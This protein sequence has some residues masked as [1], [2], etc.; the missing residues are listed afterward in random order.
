[1]KDYPVIKFTILFILGILSAEVIHLNLIF[2]IIIFLATSI[3]ILLPK[4]IKTNTYYSLL[5]LLSAGVL[6]FSI[7]NLLSKENKQSFNPYLSKIDKVKNTIA[8][9]EI[10]KIDL[11][12][13]NQLN[14]YLS[15][16]SMKSDKFFIKDKFLLLC[17]IKDSTS[18]LLSLYKELKPGNYL[19]I[20]GFYY[21]GRERRNPGEFDYDAYLKSKGILGILS[22]NDTSSITILNVE[23]NFFTNLIFQVRKQIDLQIKKFHSPETASL[24]RGLLLADRGEIN[25]QVKQQ[26]INSGVVHVLAVSGLHV[27]YIILIFLFVFGRF[28]LF[29]RSILTIAGLLC[30]MFI[31]GVPPS[32]FRATVMAIVIIIAF[33]SNRSTNIINSISIAAL[34]ILVINPN[35]IY[36]PGFQL[37]FSAVLS[38]AIIFPYLEKMI[39]SWNIQNKI[40]RYLVLFLGV[41]LSAQIGTLPLT[42]LYFNQ[43]SIIA[44]FTNLIVIPAIGVIIA[45]A[46]V[47]LVFSSILPL[48]AIYFAA[49]NDLVTKSILSIIKFSGELSFSHIKIF[50]YS[51]IDLILFY[52]ML[53]VLLY[54]LPR[55]S[56]GISKAILFV[57][58]ILNIF[59]LS[60]VD[61][62]E[63]LPD[64]SLSVFMIDV[65][66]GDSFLIKFPNSKTALIDAGNVT[67]T[68]DN[69]ERVIKPLLEY[70]GINK[71][72]YGIVSHIDSDHYAGFVS[73]VLNGLIGEIYKP[74]IDSS[75]SKDVRFEEFLRE[76][77]VP[78]NYF[79]EKK[80]QIGNVALYFLYD[81]RVESIAGESTNNRSGIIKLVYG[82]NSFLFTGDAEKNVEKIYAS[83]YRNFLD[84][85]V[86]KAGHHGSKTSSSE[87]FLDYVTPKY[88]LISAGFKNK[89]GHPAEE[90][91]QRLKMHNSKIFRTDLQ[92]AILLRSDGKEINLINW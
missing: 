18:K 4:K 86:L 3:L 16:D 42:L 21:K 77:N 81:K 72:D 80:M 23:F 9:G 84:S 10:S 60:V 92:E 67:F 12:R 39:A 74:E 82:E 68:F 34:I 46:I 13:N 58:V 54:Y 69:G 40:V 5:I 35:E 14:F 88:S 56:R 17:R 53:G 26:F 20:N 64:N 78:V 11:L 57:L 48:I 24:L 8:Y 51:V 22:V 37:S 28:N 79:S 66:Q 89:F 7:G 43:F 45:T 1:M 38:I 44:L 25:Y 47:T 87:I 76:N 59:F 71:I 19:D 85:D 75:L 91:I 90:I 49:A 33:L 30:F 50:N 73:L 32:V 63:L 36:N 31:T 62:R 2:A 61:D 29:L 70:L 65:G 83:K 15:V 6:I 27:G 41:S 52:M 55:F